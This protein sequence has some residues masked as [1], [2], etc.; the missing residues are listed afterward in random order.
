MKWS[1]NIRKRQEKYSRRERGSITIEASLSMTLFT[2][3]MVCILSFINIS[4]VQSVMSSVIN[5]STLELSQYAYF[6]KMSGLYDLEGDIQSAG[7]LAGTAINDAISSADQALAGVETI[8]A[9]F[10]GGSP[11]AVAGQD[12]IETSY[13]NLQG[14]MDQVNQGAQSISA[15]IDSLGSQIAAVKDN[16]MGY[17]KSLLA[18]GASGGLDAA[19]SHLVAA[20]LA[21]NICESHLKTD[22]QTADERL[23]AL[24]VIDGMDGLNF[25]LSTMFNKESHADI[26][27]IC[28]Y[29]VRAFP[30]LS[31]D[32]YKLTLAVSGSTRGWLGDTRAERIN[33][34]ESENPGESGGN[35]E[36]ESPVESTEDDESE[37]S[38]E[39]TEDGESGKHNGEK[40]TTAEQTLYEQKI[41]ELIQRY[42]LYA[43]DIRKFTSL[44]MYGD[45]AVR[46]IDQ[47]GEDAIL[48]LRLQREI[49]EANQDSNND[50]WNSDYDV[51]SLTR[52]HGEA[53]LILMR[54]EGTSAAY[55]LKNLSEYNKRNPQITLEDLQGAFST[56]RK[57][58]V[59]ILY[60]CGD[61]GVDALS[62]REGL[63]DRMVDYFVEIAT[64]TPKVNS[65]VVILGK[66]GEYDRYAVDSMGNPK[67]NYFHMRDEQWKLMEF[68]SGEKTERYDEIWK[69][70]ERYLKSMIN[71]EKEFYL[72]N[73]PSKEYLVDGGAP[74]FYQREIDYLRQFYDM[75]TSFVDKNGKTVWVAVPKTEGKEKQQ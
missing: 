16:P 54:Q 47:Y 50:E 60:K 69:V 31:R 70:N 61:D 27:I 3:L 64:N 23:Q 52:E 2:F 36:N 30:W 56:D 21:K 24:G 63:S 73:D 74:S 10:P 43:K 14:T 25:K 32:D 49:D 13:G 28:V 19:K 59:D 12:S 34:S 20:P 40:E 22:R 5:Q 38:V 29:Q 72:V 42:P 68:V 26:N 57:T 46:F 71:E 62:H 51:I 33:S 4:R 37:S 6:Y 53:G 67:Y 44:D 9:A 17:A 66:S 41:E 65:D 18:L 11:S 58:S 15:A 1:Q 55:A 39:S 7:G 35:G 48:A 8:Y 45:E 75:D